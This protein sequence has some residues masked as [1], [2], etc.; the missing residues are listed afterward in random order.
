MRG[1]VEVSETE[2]GQVVGGRY[3]L[4]SEI[5]H[6]GMGRVWE[7][8]DTKL[9]RLVAVKEV[10]L[11]ALPPAQQEI[12]LR[13]AEREGKN[14]AALADHPNIVTVYDVIVDGGCPWIVMQLVKGRSLRSVL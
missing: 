6:G 3:L 1:A 9:D 8:R 12:R 5:G 2:P 11:P 13:Q 10:M 14:A 4:I 7:A